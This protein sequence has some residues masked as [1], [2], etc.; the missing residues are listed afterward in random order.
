MFDLL[1]AESWSDGEHGGTGP[2][3]RGFRWIRLSDGGL[4]GAYG[5]IRPLPK[6]GPKTVKSGPK[7]SNQEIYLANICP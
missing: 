2:Y 5:G 3:V 6:L 7:P 4:A 1:A